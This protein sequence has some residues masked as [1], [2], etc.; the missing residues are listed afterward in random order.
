[1]RSAATNTH[2]VQLPRGTLNLTSI[3]LAASPHRLLVWH[4][5]AQRNNQPTTRSDS[6]L[7]E[8]QASPKPKQALIKQTPPP[9][10][11]LATTATRRV[12][13]HHVMC[14]NRRLL[15]LACLCCALSSRHALCAEHFCLLTGRCCCVHYHAAARSLCAD[16]S[17]LVAKF[18]MC[19]QT[20]PPQVSKGPAAR[21]AVKQSALQPHKF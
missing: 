18:E 1:M 14:W 6:L 2:F 7:I 17:S 15:Q 12:P 8:K 5:Y 10:E 21:R 16:F 20:R 3:A 9:T 4:H 13:T 11:R 19:S